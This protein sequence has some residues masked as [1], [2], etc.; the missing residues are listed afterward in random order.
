MSASKK[1]T[2]KAAKDLA[3]M[4]DNIQS[5]LT[6]S[7]PTTSNNQPASESRFFSNYELEKTYRPYFHP[8]G[9]EKLVE[10]VKVNVEDDGKEEKKAAAEAVVAQRPAIFNTFATAQYLPDGLCI[11]RSVGF[12][13][14]EIV[15]LDKISLNTLRSDGAGLGLAHNLE[16]ANAFYMRGS[17]WSDAVEKCALAS[18]YSSK[19]NS[20]FYL[21]NQSCQLILT[22]SQTSTSLPF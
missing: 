13:K 18:R 19:S 12:D 6:A 8:G 1:I 9:A 21:N 5:A 15:N 10:D 4:L 14:Y 3:T 22:C 16:R 2:A 17:A 7:P 11:I 20:L